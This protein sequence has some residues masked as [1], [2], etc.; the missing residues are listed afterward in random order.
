[1][2]GPYRNFPQEFAGLFP[3]YFDD[4]QGQQSMQS[5]GFY[6]GNPSYQQPL[7]DT[8]FADFEEPNRSVLPAQGS[9]RV[10][11][12]VGAAGEH[13]KFRRTRSGCYTCRNRRV[14]VNLLYVYVKQAN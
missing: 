10:R 8:S 6:S 7:L 12:R 13:V 3:P 2:A 1:M 5:A 11:K 14:K 9:S 4:G